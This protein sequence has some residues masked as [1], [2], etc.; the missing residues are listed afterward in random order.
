MDTSGLQNVLRLYTRDISVKPPGQHTKRT[1]FKYTCA[2]P[3]G[4]VCGTKEC[5]MLNWG[6]NNNLQSGVY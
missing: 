1:L 4:H 2:V 3:Q 5:K 6:G